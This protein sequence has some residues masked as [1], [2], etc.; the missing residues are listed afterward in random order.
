[1]ILLE[2]FL[3]RFYCEVGKPAIYLNGPAW[4]NTQSY[5]LPNYLVTIVSICIN[6]CNWACIARRSAA[7]VDKHRR[8]IIDVNKRHQQYL[9]YHVGSVLKSLQIDSFF[10]QFNPFLTSRYILSLPNAFFIFFKS[11]IESLR[12]GGLNQPPFRFKPYGRL[13]L[14]K[15]P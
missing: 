15:K 3:C 6:S 13:F 1:M 2:D 7:T 14:K 4:W 9:W 8:S 10:I 5:D 12:T 11:W